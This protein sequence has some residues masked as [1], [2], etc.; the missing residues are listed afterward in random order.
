MAKYNVGD[1]LKI[2]QWDDMVAEYG[3]NVEGCVIN[4]PCGF[5]TRMRD[6]CGKRFT[7]QNIDNGI[8]YPKERYGWSFSEEMLEPYTTEN[9][10]LASGFD[11]KTMIS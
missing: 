5:I 3:Y 7:V 9:L 1:V 11:F 4:V 10:S 6:L 8:Y 2:R